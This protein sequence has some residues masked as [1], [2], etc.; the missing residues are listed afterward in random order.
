MIC[1]TFLD[2]TKMKLSSHCGRKHALQLWS[3]LEN[4]SKP[5]HCEKVTFPVGGDIL[6]RG[7]VHSQMPSLKHNTLLEKIVHGVGLFCCRYRTSAT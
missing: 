1:A 4:L 5:P 7:V 6:Q 2:F 3:P